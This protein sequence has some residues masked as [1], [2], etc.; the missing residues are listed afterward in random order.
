MG[1]GCGV[2]A[3]SSA[4]KDGSGEQHRHTEEAC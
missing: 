2:P 4:T 1:L 3:F